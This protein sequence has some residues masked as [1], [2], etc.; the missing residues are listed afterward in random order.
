MHY[1]EVLLSLA[2]VL[3][4]DSK[5]GVAWLVFQNRSQCLLS[6]PLK[7]KRTGIPPFPS[8]MHKWAYQPKTPTELT[9]VGTN[10]FSEFSEILKN[11]C[12]F[13]LVETNECLLQ[14]ILLVQAVMYIIRRFLLIKKNASSYYLLCQRYLDR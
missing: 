2:A 3:L 4:L 1:K 13:L 9:C 12:S 7:N 6:V 14:I 5:E 8:T 11:R 10:Y